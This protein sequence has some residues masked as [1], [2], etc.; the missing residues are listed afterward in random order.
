M[1]GRE[2]LPVGG[3][4]APARVTRIADE[5]EVAPKGPKFGRWD[6]AIAA[7][8]RTRNAHR[9]RQEW[10]LAATAEKDARKR[11]ER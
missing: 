10:A 7:A 3:K 2:V 9:R 4:E 8:M 6:S 11:H 1:R 5:P